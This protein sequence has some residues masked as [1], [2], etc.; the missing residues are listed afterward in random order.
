MTVIGALTESGVGLK[1]I[2]SVFYVINPMFTFYC[3]NF[4]I[5]I[6]YIKNLENH[7]D[8]DFEIPLAF[9]YSATFALSLL[10]FAI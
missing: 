3:A 7:E 2:I 5:V 10:A 1:F 4:T 6:Q 8:F 9:G